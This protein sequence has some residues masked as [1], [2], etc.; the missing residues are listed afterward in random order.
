M[1]TGRVVVYFDHVLKTGTS[2]QGNW[3]GTAFIP[4]WKTIAPALGI[5]AQ[6][7]GNTV[8]WT[9]VPGMPAIGPATVTYLGAPADVISRSSSLPAAPFAGYPLT[10]I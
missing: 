1:A 3:V 4:P 8:R 6:V 9:A 10:P 7:V 2:A 5:D